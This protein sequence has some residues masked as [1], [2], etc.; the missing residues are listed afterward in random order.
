MVT[1]RA[2]EPHSEEDLTDKRAGI[3]GLALVTENGHR[4]VVVRATLSG[5]KLAHHGVVGLVLAEAVT[6][7]GV[8]QI[9]GLHAN[10]RG[11]RPDE[12]TPFHSPMV[13]IVGL[14]Q[15]VIHQPGT[16]IGAAV[17]E[18]FLR[19][20][21]GG[22]FADE[23][24]GGAP[25]ELFVRA[26]FGRQDAQLLMPLMHEA[27]DLIVHR[28]FRIQLRWQDFIRRHGDACH[29]NQ[30]H[31]AH[32]NDAFATDRTDLDLPVLIH[33][34]H[35]FVLGEIV[36]EIRHVPGCA[37]GIPSGDFEFL[38]GTFFV[39]LLARFHTY[40]V[41][42]WL[43]FDG[44]GHA[45]FDP[46]QEFQIRLALPVDARPA[47]MRHITGRLLQQQTFF[48]RGEEQATAA[49]VAHDLIVVMLW[50]ITEDGEL[51]VILPFRLGMAI[52]GST[53]G[54]HQMRHHIMDKTHRR[55]CGQ[56]RAGQR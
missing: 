43:A 56:K 50:I 31:V 45:L 40:R 15:Q 30:P 44:K 29:V 24:N 14:F 46:G 10:A 11:I 53:A 21:D 39:A 42:F 41:E 37:I 13:G 3:H 2:V 54:L 34:G 17:G 47:F 12:I 28:K 19:H 32:D 35:L 22:Q 49:I 16:F 5:E 8:E 48:R 55:F 25:E 23:I 27:V 1:F 52:A 26:G 20:F 38:R 36:G 33:H 9:D 51:E 7:P 4:T 18:K 6:Q